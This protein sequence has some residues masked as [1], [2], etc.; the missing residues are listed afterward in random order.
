MNKAWY[1]VKL[2]ALFEVLWIFGFNVASSWWHW[3]IIILIIILD[4]TFLSKACEKLPTGTVYAVFAAF[5]TLGT[6][7]MDIFIFGGSINFI[8]VFFMIVI[9]IGVIILNFAD[10]KTEKSPKEGSN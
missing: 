6:A 3:P 10:N 7:F 1:Y 9:V 5:G 4:F 8:K 2:T